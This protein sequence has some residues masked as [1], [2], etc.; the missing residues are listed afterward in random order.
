MIAHNTRI[1]LALAILLGCQS[2]GY[3]PASTP[4]DRIAC[5]QYSSQFA[6]VYRGGAYN[7]C[8][9]EA[10]YSEQYAEHP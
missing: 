8:M 9:R 10:G 7:D 1:M 6:P 4:A 3:F 5:L 2:R